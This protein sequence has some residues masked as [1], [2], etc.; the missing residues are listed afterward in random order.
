[1]TDSKSGHDSKKDLESI[2][3]EDAD[4]TLAADQIHRAQRVVAAQ[5]NDVEEARMFLA[6]LGIADAPDLGGPG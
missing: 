3:D 2:V 6:M 1:M 4:S 5:A